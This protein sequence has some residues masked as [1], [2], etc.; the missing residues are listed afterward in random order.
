MPREAIH[1]IRSID[2]NLFNEAEKKILYYQKYLNELAQRVPTPSSELFR[3]TDAPFAS[4]LMA[5]LLANTEKSMDMYCQ[6][7]RPGI[8]CGKDENDSEGFCGSYWKI[9]EK[10]FSETIKSKS[11][12]DGSIRI[13]I[14]RRDWFTN[15]PFQVI[16]NALGNSDMNNKI[17]V[18]QIREDARK[19]IENLLGKKND[20]TNY[21]FSI[22][23]NKA[24][25]LE[26]DPDRFKA[27]GSF[28]DTTW[29]NLLKGMFD[30][31][32]STATPISLAEIK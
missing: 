4:I 3:N 9:F 2:S 15:K 10:F 6:G 1:S 12:G 17:L 24:F 21:N 25:R 11:F 22:F 32:F 27:I 26:Y 31:A 5:T 29:C 16:K 18:R 19:H 30:Y 14:Q 23:D 20:D 13:L 28:N 8:L 7:L